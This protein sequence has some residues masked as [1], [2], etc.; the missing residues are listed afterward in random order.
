MPQAQA[1][2]KKHN[3]KDIWD[4]IKH[5]NICIIGVQ[6]EKKESIKKLFEEITTEKSS[7]LKKKT[8]I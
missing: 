4:N 7:N 6:K 5:I 1:K 3:L 8:N 2:K